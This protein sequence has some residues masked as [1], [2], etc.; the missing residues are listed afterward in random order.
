[1]QTLNAFSGAPLA[2][3]FYNRIMK[4][5][6]FPAVAAVI[7][8]SCTPAI[9]PTDTVTLNSNKTGGIMNKTA[10]KTDTNTY[11]Y[12]LSCGC[13]FEL[14][15][16]NE[17]AMKNIYYDISNIALKSSS[18]LVKAYPIAALTPGTYTG[19]L[20]VVTLKPD[21]NPDLRDTLRDTVI[22]K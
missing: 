19:W 13:E 9:T 5:L 15:V 2:F 21:T 22:V 6:C 3:I 20:A 16:E 11:N 7:F 10:T 17:D 4:T 8:Y 12:A 14:K 18:H 1:M